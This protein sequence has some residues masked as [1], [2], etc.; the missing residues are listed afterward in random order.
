M[1]RTGDG[2]RMAKENFSQDTNWSNIYSFLK[3]F[4][5]KWFQTYRCK[6]ENSTQNTHITFTQTH[7]L[8][9]ICPLALSF[10]LFHVYFF[11]HTNSSAF[12][13]DTHIYTRD[14]HVQINTYHRLLGLCVEFYVKTTRKYQRVVGS[15]WRESNRGLATWCFHGSLLL[16]PSNANSKLSSVLV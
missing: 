6:N 1:G 16:P 13:L 12:T 11:S 2:M 9:N 10:A 5:W 7:L 14:T 3:L 4:T 8:L 15:R